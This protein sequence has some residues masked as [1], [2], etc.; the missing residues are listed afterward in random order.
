MC[1]DVVAADGRAPTSNHVV[2]PRQ[3]YIPFAEIRNMSPE[4]FVSLLADRMGV[5]GVVAGVN[6]RFGRQPKSRPLF[7]LD[8]ECNVSLTRRRPLRLSCFDADR[9]A[10]PL[11]ATELPAMLNSWYCWAKSTAFRYK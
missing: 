5:A 7:T 4:E 10:S 1:R 6:Y 3:R 11:K 9:S 2:A 8:S